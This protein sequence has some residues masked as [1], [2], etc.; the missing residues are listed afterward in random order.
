MA[1]VRFRV[2][3]LSRPSGVASDWL[4]G[5]PVPDKNAD[6]AGR[7]PIEEPAEAARV[8]KRQANEEWA[9]K[10]EGKDTSDALP[11]P[12]PGESEEG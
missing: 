1:G 4:G 10:A 8:G 12:L 5:V 2:A 11:D 3:S 9:E 7:G 6:K